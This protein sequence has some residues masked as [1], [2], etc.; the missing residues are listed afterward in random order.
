MCGDVHILRCASN[1]KRVVIYFCEPDIGE[2]QRERNIETETE[3]GERERDSVWSCFFPSSLSGAACVSPVV[4]W[5]G[6]LSLYTTVEMYVNKGP[7][8]LSRV[9]RMG[10]GDCAF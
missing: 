10:P 2:R 5:K 9:W 3:G 6:A 7:R 4:P 1:K 8:V